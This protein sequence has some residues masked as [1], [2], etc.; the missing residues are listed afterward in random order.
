MR[1]REK[2]CRLLPRTAALLLMVS[3]LAGVLGACGG[4]DAPGENGIS[5]AGEQAAAGAGGALSGNDGAGGTADG[6]DGETGAEGEEGAGDGVGTPSFS[7]FKAVDIDG[8]DVDQSIFADYDL[9]MVNVWGTFC[10]YCLQ[11]MPELGEISEE[12][13]DEG[14]QVVGIVIDVLNEDLSVNTEQIQLAR[15]VVEK[16]EANYP[17]LVPSID[18]LYA[19]IAS[20]R[21]YPTTFFVDKNGNLVGDVYSGARSKDKWERIIRDTLGEVR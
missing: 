17:H 15:E 20:I 18:L 16:T 7:S 14:V 4:G 21:S 11:E 2:K 12:Y 19:G 10:T 13:A 9:T 1:M 8:N 5:G 3:L 6:T